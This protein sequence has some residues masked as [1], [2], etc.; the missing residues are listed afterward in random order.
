MAISIRLVANFIGTAVA[1]AAVAVTYF[2]IHYFKYE[3]KV[4]PI[5]INDVDS[6]SIM[7]DIS[8]YRGKKIKLTKKDLRCLELNIYY[9]AGIEDEF[10]KIAVAQVTY[11]RLKAKRWGNTICKVVYS[12]HQFSW[13]KQKKKP[14]KGELWEDSKKA[15]KAFVNGLRI[16]GL[17]DSMYY[18]ATW[19]D[20]APAWA[21]HKIKVH[22]IGQHIF[23]RPKA[24]YETASN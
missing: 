18:H 24:K 5:E 12:P 11:N 21:A 10:G 19:M 20:S 6:T 8:Y 16:N 3:P 2:D 9:E 14:P 15:A 22:E 7:E 23:Y 17:S 4:Y 13:T 1:A